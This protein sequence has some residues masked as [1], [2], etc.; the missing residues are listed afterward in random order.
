MRLTPLI[1]GTMVATA[2]LGGTAIYYLSTP[3][4]TIRAVDMVEIVEGTLERSA[5]IAPWPPALDNQIVG[6][7]MSRDLLIQMLSRIEALPGSFVRSYTN[8]SIEMWTATGL[9]AQCQI[10]DGVYPNWTIALS[11]GIPIYGLANDLSYGPQTD[12]LFEAYRLLSAMTCTV[13]SATLVTTNRLAASIPDDI[14]WERTQYLLSQTNDPP[15]DTDLIPDDLM[16][17]FNLDTDAEVLSVLDIPIVDP[18][19]H[20]RSADNSLLERKI[21]LDRIAA[22]FYV[23]IDTEI[24]AEVGLRSYLYG[25]YWWRAF[26]QGDFPCT[27]HAGRAEGYLELP[28]ADLGSGVTARVDLELCVT[29]QVIYA[30]S[31]FTFITNQILSNTVYSWTETCFGTITGMLQHTIPRL[32]PSIFDDSLFVNPGHAQANVEHLETPYPYTNQFYYLHYGYHGYQFFQHPFS[33]EVRYQFPRPAVI[34]W[35]FIYCK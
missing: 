15:A 33:A 11:N 12:V 2:F 32:A 34:T 7:T 23:D 21:Q 3:R 28:I 20:W 16:W 17:A 29:G 27:R 9:W 26:A 31:T 6:S 13:R 22:W 4:P 8:G 1:Y 18:G 35:S 5:A 14:S 19:E 25:D 30:D 24:L 10:A